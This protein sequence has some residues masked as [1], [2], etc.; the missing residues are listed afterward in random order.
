MPLKEKFSI[1]N[2]TLRSAMTKYDQYA[3]LV[4]NLTGQDARI[5]IVDDLSG[6]MITN[7][8]VP[9]IFIRYFM[10]YNSVGSQYQKQ[11]NNFYDY[12]KENYADY[13]LLLSYDTSLD[14]CEELLTVG[15]DYLI[16]IR[17]ES[18]NSDPD[19][20]IFSSFDIYDLGEAVR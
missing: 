19:E 7:M 3:E 15:K 6:E 8:N 9:A 1:S 11:T 13:A 12:A 17:A 4:V 2:G 16:N 10:M 14:H 18:I 20:C 5:L